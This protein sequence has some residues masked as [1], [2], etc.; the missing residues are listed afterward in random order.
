METKIENNGGKE[1]GNNNHIKHIT[2]NININA[3]KG[4]Y[5]NA[6][7]SSLFRTFS[8]IFVRTEF[9]TCSGRSAVQRVSERASVVYSFV[10]RFG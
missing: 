9:G 4:N 10:E 3:N 8:S 7:C 1:Q 5:Y 6:K 2:I